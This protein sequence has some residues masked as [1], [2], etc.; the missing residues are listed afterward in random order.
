[1]QMN[2]VTRPM[3]CKWLS[4]LLPLHANTL[5]LFSWE[6]DQ[7]PAV[8]NMGAWLQQYADSLSPSPWGHTST[9]EK[10]SDK[11]FELLS[12]TY[13]IL[14]QM[15]NRFHSAPVLTSVLA[16]RKKCTTFLREMVHTLRHPVGFFPCVTMGKTWDHGMENV[17]WPYK[18][19]WRSCKV[20][21]FQKEALPGKRLPFPEGIDGLDGLLIL[22]CEMWVMEIEV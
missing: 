13:Q 20:K 19:V 18:H 11:S 10:P 2:W 15:E 5:A 9:A 14:S 6:D 3:W 21:W 4:R 12:K 7:A 16:I 17:L 22:I 8:G 1:M